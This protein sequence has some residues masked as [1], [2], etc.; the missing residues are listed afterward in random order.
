MLVRLSLVRVDTSPNSV[1]VWVRVSDRVRIAF[2]AVVAPVYGGSSYSQFRTSA[3]LTT[4]QS[5]PDKG[6]LTFVLTYAGVLLTRCVPDKPG[7]L[8]R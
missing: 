8:F 3:L 6:N 4:Y 1:R 5:P 2:L 7:P